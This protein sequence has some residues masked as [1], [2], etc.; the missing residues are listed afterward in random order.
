ME[1]SESKEEIFCS[2]LEFTYF[3]LKMCRPQPISEGSL[4][5]S[6]P[7]WRRKESMLQLQR[8]STLV[9][10]HG[11]APLLPL[12]SLWKARY[13]VFF[14]FTEEPEKQ[15]G[16]VVMSERGIMKMTAQPAMV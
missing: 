15:A 7:L 9:L 4:T 1:V 3:E 8:V 12:G 10:H 14:L 11:L 13:R 2:L 6:Q 5:P 16:R